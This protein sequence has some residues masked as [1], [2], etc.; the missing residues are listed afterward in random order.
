MS[1]FRPSVLPSSLLLLAA[2]ATACAPTGAP[3]DARSDLR[4]EGSVPAGVDLDEVA[5]ELGANEIAVFA[6]P[7]TGEVATIVR[8]ESALARDASSEFSVSTAATCPD[9]GDPTCASSVRTIEIGLRHDSG[10]AGETYTV[11]TTR[12]S[13]YGAARTAPTTW[14]LDPGNTITL[15]TTGTLPACSAFGHFFEVVG[16]DPADAALRFE[17]AAPDRVQL[18]ATSGVTMSQ[19]TVEA[20]LLTTGHTG[21]RLAVAD[22]QCNIPA[23]WFIGSNQGRSQFFVTQDPRAIGPAIDDG[24]WHFVAGTFD[25]TT[26]RLYTDG[27]LS[28]SFSGSGSS[29][30]LDWQLGIGRNCPPFNDAGYDGMVDDVSIWNV[31]RTPAQIQADMA[32]FPTSGA[33]LQAAYDLNE[34]AG[35]TTTDQSGHGRDGTLGTSTASGEADDPDWF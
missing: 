7:G 34:G 26:A 8:A 20:W 16:P 31:V 5:R 18:A 2:A 15:T 13:N 24:G 19:F 35:Q 14:T 12:A 11:H 17:A 28:D 4:I 21:D 23:G 9:C 33:G 27:V 1:T 32:T 6:D 22:H 25:G 29:T 3:P 30:G 10:V